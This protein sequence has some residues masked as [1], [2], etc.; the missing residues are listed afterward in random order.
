MRPILYTLL[1]LPLALVPADAYAQFGPLVPEACRACPCGFGGVLAIIQNVMNFLIA[2]GIIIA[3]LIIVWGGILYVLSPANPE[4]RSTANKMLLNA[5]IGLL[6]TLSAWLIVDFVMKTLYGGQFGPWN[7]ILLA[8]EGAACI[9]AR[10]NSALFSGT[11]I[12]IPPT[13]TS[14]TTG[15]GGSCTPI[16]DS[17]LVTF[18]PSATDGQVRKGTADTVERFMRMRAAAQA[19]GITLRAGSAYRSPEEGEALWRSRGCRIVN[20]RTVCNGAIVAVPC[21]LGGSGSNHTRGTAID[22]QTNAAGISWM[23]QNAS[24]FGFYNAIASE[25]WHWSSTGR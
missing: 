20:G 12:A 8:G 7:S 16:P 13:E 23:R 25:P 1:L 4:N 15:G 6:I 22:I 11:I 21:S 5:V 24:R 14:D 3:T 10:E 17:Q 19:D 9:E 2:I 18:D